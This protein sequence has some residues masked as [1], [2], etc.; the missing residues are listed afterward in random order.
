[1]ITLPKWVFV[2]RIVQ[3]LLALVVLG[4]SAY[5]IYWVPYSVSFL[6]QKAK[7][8]LIQADSNLRRGV[9]PSIKV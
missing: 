4:L 5:G 6:K 1:V 7:S 2:I 8:R 3:A 9:L